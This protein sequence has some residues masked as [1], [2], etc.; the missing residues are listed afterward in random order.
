MDGII[1]TPIKFPTYCSQISKAIREKR[2][3]RL[4]ELLVVEGDLVDQV[5]AG[6]IG[7]SK[8]VLN[9]QVSHMP[10]PFPELIIS[11]I[12][13][14]VLSRQA[15]TN[16]DGASW[17][18]AY[19]EQTTCLTSFMNKYLITQTSWALPVLYQLCRDLRELGEKA[20]DHLFSV[21]AQKN[22]VSLED[23]ARHINK[24]FTICATDRTFKGAES[25]QRG[26]YY[27][28]GMTMKCYFKVNRPTLC[29][30]IIR[31][32]GSSSNPQPFETYPIGHRV[33]WRYYMGML[34]FL[35]EDYSKAE[36]HLLW[37]FHNCHH[38]ATRNLSQ[39]LH[40]LLPLRLLL[41]K[42]PSAHLLS[43]FP[44]LSQLYTPFIEAIRKADLKGYDEAMARAQKRLVEGGV[45][46]ILERGRE[47]VVRGV[48]KDV[49]L[50]LGKVSRVPIGSFKAGL[51]LAGVDVEAEEVECMVA[52][53]IYKGYMKGYISHA[54]QLVVL[55]AKQAFPSLGSRTA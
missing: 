45:W 15:Y 16:E 55:S 1:L 39:I 8:Q 13:V 44:L 2:G 25:K 49:W 52:N 51:A 28:A 6:L 33:T 3:D 21:G 37:S 41:G 19:K 34:A 20:D 32:I 11:H 7:S 40:Y 38:L 50:A 53:M 9:P 47:V 42:L 14:L 48:F 46:L 12:Q 35:E 4:A 10:A 22:P 5:V 27:V 29:K 30:N 24:A 31:A 18:A 23:A 43:L 26:I 54:H 17:V 36:D